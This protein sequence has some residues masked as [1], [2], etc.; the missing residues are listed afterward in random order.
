MREF[1]FEFGDPRPTSHALSLFLSNSPGDVLFS[2]LERLTYE[3]R[4]IPGYLA[5]FRLL[6]SPSL[7]HVTLRLPGGPAELGPLTALAQTVSFLPSSLKKL[8]VMCGQ[9]SS[10]ELRNTMSSFVCRCG[11]SLKTF[12]TSVPLRDAAIL[13]LMELP[14]LS[15]W[16]TSQGPPQAVSTFNI[17]PSLKKLRI[18]QPDAFPWLDVLA[19]DEHLGVLQQYPGMTTRPRDMLESIHCPMMLDPKLLTTI[20]KFRNLV[21]FRMRSDCY[22]GKGQC[23]FHLTDAD[24]HELAAALPRLKNL[25]LGHPCPSNTCKT[26]VASLMSISVHC[27]DLEALEIHF[28]T[29]TM[30]SDVQRLLNESI[31]KDKAKCN[32]RDFHVGHMPLEIERTED[33]ETVAWG[34]ALIFPSLSIERYPETE[35]TPRDLME[36]ETGIANPS[37]LVEILDPHTWVHLRA[38]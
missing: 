31:W 15:S 36:P 7:N 30:V 8:F 34:F 18:D 32:L 37:S 10:E 14:N 20:G 22:L 6:I 2:N 25:L 19:S 38:D 21:T 35:D 28:N 12:K 24:V 9:K 5:L 26:T 11:S 17:F 1:Y 3:V 33:E 23:A 27:L 13:R 4:D 16:G 29:Q